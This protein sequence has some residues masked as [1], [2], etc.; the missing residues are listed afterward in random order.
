MKYWQQI[1]FWKKERKKTFEQREKPYFRYFC[2]FLRIE[3]FW[4][5]SILKRLFQE[6]NEKKLSGQKQFF[7]LKLFDRGHAT[8]IRRLLR[9]GGFWRSRKFNFF[10]SISKNVFGFDRDATIV[11]R[12]IFFILSDLIHLANCT[13]FFD[14]IASSFA[15]I[16]ALVFEL[17]V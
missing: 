11:S 2:F 1:L 5:I 12:Y 10:R 15:Y 3:L 6:K 8:Q 9:F 14:V 7:S 17:T 16:S 13:D 4:P